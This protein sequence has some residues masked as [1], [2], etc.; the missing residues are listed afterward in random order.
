MASHRLGA[1]RG[2]RA[3]HG[4]ADQS[5]RHCHLG[6]SH[7]NPSISGGAPRHSAD[8]RRSQRFQRKGSAGTAAG[9]KPDWPAPEDFLCPE[10]ESR[11]CYAAPLPSEG[12]VREFESSRA[13]QTPPRLLFSTIR[14]AR[15]RGKKFVIIEGDG[16]WSRAAFAL[17]WSP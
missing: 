4:E 10:W 2:R 16:V 11:T 9:A 1:R 3:V 6:L 13:R 7:P 14:N 5:A 15:L 12:R 17:D 8:V